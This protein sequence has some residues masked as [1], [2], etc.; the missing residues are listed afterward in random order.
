METV[1]PGQRFFTRREHPSEW[2]VE[3]IVSGLVPFPHVRMRR[4]SDQTTR[5]LLALSVLT[6]PRFFRPVDAPRHRH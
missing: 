1:K 6:D 2:I 5:K 3:S 4:A